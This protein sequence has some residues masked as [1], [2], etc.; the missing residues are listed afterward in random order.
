MDNVSKIFANQVEQ[1]IMEN[2]LNPIFMSARQQ[3][4]FQSNKQRP[5]DVQSELYGYQ[6]IAEDINA[7]GYACQIWPALPGLAFI[8][9]RKTDE[10]Q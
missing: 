7:D 5:V 9:P 8:V 3:I 4:V 1:A 2:T 10:R 6:A